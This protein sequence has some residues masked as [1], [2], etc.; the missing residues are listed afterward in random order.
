MKQIAL[1]LDYLHSCSP[2]VIHG[3]LRGVSVA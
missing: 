1:G 3:D 2:P